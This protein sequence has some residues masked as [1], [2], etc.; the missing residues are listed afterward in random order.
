MPIDHTDPLAVKRASEANRKARLRPAA[1][2]LG[3]HQHEAPLLLAH[4]QIRP[5]VGGGCKRLKSS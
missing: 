3:L 2:E 5:R 4:W 1:P